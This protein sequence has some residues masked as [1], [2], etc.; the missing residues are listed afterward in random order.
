MEITTNLVLHGTQINKGSVNRGHVFKDPEAEAKLTLQGG[1]TMRSAW[2]FVSIG[3]K[4]K[5][6]T[7]EKA[8][9]AGDKW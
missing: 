9:R 1:I 7:E 4:R 2:P 5:E 6:S 8:P 3:E